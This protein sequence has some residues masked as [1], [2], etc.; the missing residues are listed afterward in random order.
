[1]TEQK[2]AALLLWIEG[3]EIRGRWPL[4]K[5]ST[6]IGRWED[7]DI[8]VDDRWVSRYHARI[9]RKDDHYVIEDLS[10]K[11]GT[12]VNG[13]RITERT[14]LSDGDQVQVTPLVALTFVGYAS[15]APL[16]TEMGP[17]GLEFDLT[18]RQIYVCGKLLDPPLSQAQFS[19]LSLLAQQAG[20]VYSRDEVIAAVW[21]EAEADG[22]SDEAI[23]ALVRRIRLRLRELD[24]KQEYIVTIRGYGFKLEPEG[25]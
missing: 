20:R 16:P 14:V 8:V 2:E 5:P 19:F 7:N 25:T 18:A 21:P 24:P 17:M 15:T 22:V 11:N 23:D 6:T 12:L 3:E 10:S 9:Y 1:M 13:R 4:D